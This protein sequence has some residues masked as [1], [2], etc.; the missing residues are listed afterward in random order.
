MYMDIK[1][2]SLWPLDKVS[3]I[4]VETTGLK[5][6]YDEILSLSIVDGNGTVLFDELFRP[7]RRKSWKPAEKVNGISPNDVK[8][9]RRIS[10]A[11]KEI[12]PL[13]SSD[14]LVVAYNLW[15]D[16][17][18]LREAGVKVPASNHFDV[19]ADYSEV[20]GPIGEDGE[21][22]N[23]RLVN[24]ARKYG[25]TFDAHKSVEDAKATA[26]VFRSLL[27]DPKYQAACDA[28]DK[29]REKCSQL[30][31]RQKQEKKED[32]E[33]KREP[34]AGIGC[35]VG[36]VLIVLFAVLFAMLSR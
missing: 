7:E 27:A 26:F 16:V 32:E 14:R 20:Y 29:E 2:A 15:F 33:R 12:E 21:R 22:K 3:V 1:E 31:A 23:V 5:H 10:E 9:A 25:Y 17:E 18:F 30:I 36:I 34:G 35:I 24:A 8:N 13:L 19:M 28:M 6:G 4:D 11:I